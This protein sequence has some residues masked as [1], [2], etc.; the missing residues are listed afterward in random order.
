MELHIQQQ[1]SVHYFSYCVV[2]HTVL[3]PDKPALLPSGV[4][5]TGQNQKSCIE[6][7]HH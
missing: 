5:R 6:Y 2:M 7:Y 3:N 1:A 4:R